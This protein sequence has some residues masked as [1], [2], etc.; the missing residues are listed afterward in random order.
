[1]AFIVH[2]QDTRGVFEDVGPC[3]HVRSGA[4]AIVG[5]RSHGIRPGEAA[6]PALGCAPPVIAAVLPAITRFGAFSWD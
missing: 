6:Q 1:V 5:D 3:C 2:N 4:V